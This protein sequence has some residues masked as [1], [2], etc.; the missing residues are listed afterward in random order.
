MFEIYLSNN[1]LKTLKRLDKRIVER[2]R[3][4]L[5][6]LETS[7]LPIRG[8]DIKKII[9]A[10]DVYRVRISDYRVIYKIKWEK[11]E[12]DVIKIAKRDEKT[13]KKL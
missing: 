5:L 8:Y 6:N 11:K 4:L 7:P 1:S 10:E 12:I 2:I 13:Y 9:D 3:K